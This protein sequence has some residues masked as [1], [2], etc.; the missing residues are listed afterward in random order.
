MEIGAC[1]LPL[2]SQ[3]SPV[4]RAGEAER[5]GRLQRTRADAQIVEVGGEQV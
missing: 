3:S 5:P 4:V 2:T 1:N